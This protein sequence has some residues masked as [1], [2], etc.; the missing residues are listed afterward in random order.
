MLKYFRSIAMRII[1][2]TYLPRA[3][4]A[5]CGYSHSL[6]A[7]HCANCRSRSDDTYQWIR[8]TVAAIARL[9]NRISK[10]IISAAIEVDGK[11]KNEYSQQ[12]GHVTDYIHSLII[13][14]TADD[15]A[16]Y[17][18]RNRW[19]STNTGVYT[20]VSQDQRQPVIRLTRS[21]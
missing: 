6:E 9:R 14:D 4:L 16:P 13:Y 8:Y 10:L 20:K 2:S 1:R 3:H 7:S 19:I 17:V 18:A 5:Q 21:P 15:G 12:M 11:W